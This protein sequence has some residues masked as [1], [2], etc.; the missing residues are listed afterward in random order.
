MSDDH[1]PHVDAHTG[2][3]T[4]GHEWDGIR[5]L[6]TPLPQWWL[7]I[8]YG[9]IIWAVFYVI[10]YPAI[11]LWQS[12]TTGVLGW[13]SRG[14]V[15]E[16]IAAL[17]AQRGPMVAKLASASLVDIEKDPQMRSFAIAEGKAAFGNNCAPCHGA[18]AGGSKGYPNL[19]DDD[20]IWGGK[21]EQISATI[22]HGIRSGDPDAHQGNMPAFG[23]DG[24]LKADEISTVADY[25][26]SLSGLEV[27]KG[28]DLKKGAKI[29]ADNCA[30]CH[31]DQGKGNME[32]GA[33]NLTDAIWLYGSDKATIVEGLTYG[34]GGVMPAWKDRLEATTIKA[35]TVYVHTLGGGQ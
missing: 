7:T 4:T 3:T 10:A 9:T 19:N 24:I 5:E 33:P 34:R 26:R 27:T 23:H 32:L 1:T 29:F 11:P 13:S 15:N 31:G 25:V 21:L 18:G 6:N 16:D 20:W 2:T 30:A 28:A 22:T 8:L 35:L 17:R 12:F 14:A